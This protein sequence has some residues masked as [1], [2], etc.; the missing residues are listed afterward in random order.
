MDL[1]EEYD[2]AYRWRVMRVFKSRVSHLLIVWGPGGVGKSTYIRVKAEEAFGE[3]NVIVISGYLTEKGL[4]DL[5]WVLSEK[6][7]GVLIIDNA[8]ESLFTNNMQ[9]SLLEQATEKREYRTVYRLTGRA[10]EGDAVG[11]VR[12]GPGHKV[13]I[14]TNHFPDD[15][16]RMQAL[17]TR[18]VLVEFDTH[19]AHRAGEEMMYREL[20]E[21]AEKVKEVLVGL[22]VYDMLT[23]RDFADIV[24]MYRVIGDGEVVL[25][26][27]AHTFYAK[28]RLLKLAKDIYTKY[29][30]G[31]ARA[32]YGRA[33]LREWENATGLSARTYKNYVRTLRVLGVLEDRGARE[34]DSAV[35]RVLGRG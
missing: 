21:L 24:D 5:L 9:R 2:R 32:P 13:V 18:A 30:R 26:E 35:D 4:F 33:A 10:M 28:N 14:I 23:L 7:R 29:S 15:D 17:K 12:L 22:G 27:C 8:E 34:V 25:R 31:V 16:P 19:T 1:I 3:E 20:G 6:D 11:E